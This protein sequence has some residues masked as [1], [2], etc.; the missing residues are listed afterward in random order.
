MGN[1]V[2][3][4]RV[5]GDSFHSLENERVMTANG[6]IGKSCILGILCSVTFAYTWF[7]VLAGYMDKANMLCNVGI[8]GGLAL[9]LFICFGPKNKSLMI[10]TPLYAMCEGL[11]LG[12]ISVIVNNSYP[13]VA[14]Q[15]AIA[16]ILAFFAMLFCYKAGIIRCTQK[17]QAVIIISTFAIFLLYMSSL[18]LSFFK[19]SVP[20]IYSNS[21]IGI[22]FS[23][24]VVIVA[25]LNLIID[26]DRIQGYSHRAPA[27]F[28]WYYGFSLL[29]TIVW[30]YIEFLRLF[31]KLS[32]R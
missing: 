13:G 17:F 19:V 14:S 2:L 31:A 30:M 12:Y 27:I 20:A 5:I 8:W 9:C 23:V 21:P 22:L 10:T 29:V 24:I 18:I 6:T 11:A 4:E 3:N 28:E 32:R 15:A 25:S 1:P 7:L 16:T 26:F